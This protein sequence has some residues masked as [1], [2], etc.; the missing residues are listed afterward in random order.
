MN[1]RQCEEKGAVVITG[2]S[3]GIGRASA[4]HLDKTGFQVFAGVRKRADAESL[5]R[6]SSSRLVPIIIDVADQASVSEASRVVGKTVGTKGLS[7]LVNNAG[8]TISCPI[9]FFPLDQALKQLNVN[10]VGH[11]A[12]MQAFLPLIRKGYGRIVNIG[13]IG[14]VQATPTMGLYD[15]SK[16]GMHALTDA[17]R[18]EL[19]PWGIPVILV[20]PGNIATPIWTKMQNSVLGLSGAARELYG[21]MVNAIDRSV[22]KMAGRGISP[23]VV[24]GIVLKALT[25]EKPKARYM[26]GPDAVVQVIMSKLLC[27]KMRDGLVM[28]VLGFG[29]QVLP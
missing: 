21:P 6:E 26:A 29:K 18:M 25:V 15:A 10:L 14:G 23:G 22:K 11:I 13:S 28:K 20:I 17:L 27:D 16:A 24:A 4:L 5:M 1:S 8:I 2:A 12:V 9:E 19:S 3:T 7:G